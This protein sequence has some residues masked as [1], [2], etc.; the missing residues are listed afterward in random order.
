MLRELYAAQQDGNTHLQNIEN[1]LP[2]QVGGVMPV[3]PLAQLPMGTWKVTLVTVQAT[4]TRVD[5]TPLANRKRVILRALTGNA[6]NVF[7]HDDNTVS[8]TNGYP[9]YDKESIDLPLSPTAQIWA[10][11]ATGTHSLWMIEMA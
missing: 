5:P 8:T 9:I 11:V 6:D 3:S 2:A 7:I 1:K 4:A 10:V